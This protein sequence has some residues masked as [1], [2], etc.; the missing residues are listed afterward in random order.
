MGEEEAQVPADEATDTIY[1]V[2]EQPAPDEAGS[3]YAPV[4]AAPPPPTKRS[5]V[6]YAVVA[7][8]VAAIVILAVLFLA[9]I[10]P[11][12]HASS[13]G[14]TTELTYSQA[15]AA[16][17]ATEA[18]Y[19]SG[20]WSPFF[21]M[22][23]ALATPG[24]LPWAQIYT[25]N[26]FTQGA[27]IACTGVAVDTH[28]TVVLPA[29]T[30]DISNGAAPVWLFFSGSGATLL[31]VAVING[32][33]TVWEKYTGTGCALLTSLE[34]LGIPGGSVD[35]YAALLTVL[36]N[37]G[38]Q[39][40]TAHPG[41]SMYYSAEGPALSAS[42]STTWDIVYSTCPDTGNPVKGTTYYT[43][44]SNVSAGS[45][46]LVGAVT[47]G[48]ANCA[49]FSP[50]STPN[51]APPST[52]STPCSN[53]PMLSNALAIKSGAR[54]NS[55][56]EWYASVT[57]AAN[58]LGLSDVRLVLLNAT[59][60]FVSG[61]IAYGFE[62]ESVTGC[63]LAVGGFA[64]AASNFTTPSSGAC[65]SGTGAAAAISAGDTFVVNSGQNTTYNDTLVIEGWINYSGNVTCVLR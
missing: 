33:A 6:L 16:A 29:Y 31:L 34:N 9:G 46:A 2:G 42:G 21:V 40:L 12:H 1:G 59:G 63:G 58:G 26:L 4:Q 57:S 44:Y 20:S 8:V 49:T 5:P 7:V 28:T 55:L 53:C 65:S 39:F 3:V 43:M 50:I 14:A 22:G 27:S 45:G 51:T 56:G 19:G 36:D 17:N 41:G 48:A 64:E 24:E 32:T 62:L 38:G 25:S 60:Q 15:Q 18:S 37:G 35:T 47:S 30:G 10:G 52:S 11:F 61:N 13:S 54:T 23:L